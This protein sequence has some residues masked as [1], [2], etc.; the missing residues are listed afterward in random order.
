MLK[1]GHSAILS[2]FIKL[3]FVIKIFVL[4]I[5][6]WLLKTGFT[7]MTMTDVI[8]P[9]TILIVWNKLNKSTHY[10]IDVAYSQ[11][12]MINTP[13]VCF[14]SLRM[15]TLNALVRLRSA[16]LR[17]NLRCFLFF[18]N[19]YAQ[20]RDW[21]FMYRPDDNGL[22][23]TEYVIVKFSYHWMTQI[24]K[25]LNHHVTSKVKISQCIASLKGTATLKA[26]EYE[27]RALTKLC[28]MSQTYQNHPVFGIV[29]SL[30]PNQLCIN[31]INSF[32]LFI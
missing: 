1:G 2:T 26:N 18:S 24:E 32:M 7:S 13:I 19:E 6:E 23:R 10:Y 30:S 16:Q 3:P 17:Q 22:V 25:G 11:L 31:R 9:L 8:E 28:N 4:L 29:T 5:F 12:V 14:H 21:A 20:T 15:Q 27:T